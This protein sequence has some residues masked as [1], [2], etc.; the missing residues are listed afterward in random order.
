MLFNN[1]YFLSLFRDES[2]ADQSGNSG[3]QYNYI[4]LGFHFRFVQGEITHEKRRY[5]V[6]N[7]LR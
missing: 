2:P 5:E 6:M 1:Q 3:S 4:I 7:I